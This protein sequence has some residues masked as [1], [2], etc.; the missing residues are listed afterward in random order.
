MKDGEVGGS[1]MKDGGAAVFEE[2]F[3]GVCLG[4]V[5]GRSN[6][7]HNQTITRVMAAMDAYRRLMASG[8]PML[9]LELCSAQGGEWE[10]K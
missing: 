4:S 5:Y 10:N 6:A 8:S 7:T 2:I 3:Q 9:E 1:G